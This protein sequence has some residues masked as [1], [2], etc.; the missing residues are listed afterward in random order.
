MK[1]IQSSTRAE[2]EQKCFEQRTHDGS[3]KEEAWKVSMALERRIFAVL[4]GRPKERRERGKATFS[5]I[6]QE[7]MQTP[8]N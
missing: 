2:K 8:L 3:I 6:L 7:D 4:M 5:G 1:G